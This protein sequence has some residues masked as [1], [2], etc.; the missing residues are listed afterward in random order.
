MTDA[1]SFQPI[2]QQWV[3]NGAQGMAVFGDDAKLFVVFRDKTIHNPAKSEA[4]G[5]PEY[6]VVTYV[7]IQ[8]PGDNLSITDRPATEADKRRFANQ[9]KT[10]QDGRGEEQPGTPI[11]LLFPAHP[12]LVATM[13]HLKITTVQALANLD[14]HG[15]NTLGM[16][17]QEFKQKAQKYLDM[18]KEG[19]AYTRMEGLLA[20][21]DTTIAAQDN[22]IKELSDRLDKLTKMV[23]AGRV[24]ITSETESAP[25][26]PQPRLRPRTNSP[27]GTG[28]I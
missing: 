26:A 27:M 12:E 7:R 19:E 24:T 17:G 1:F 2:N 6:D 8:Q 9:F 22:Q 13:R 3:A 18:A 25:A 11:D 21:R 23:E 28:E 14:G 5:R 20:S 16:G 4:V 15:M 10:Y